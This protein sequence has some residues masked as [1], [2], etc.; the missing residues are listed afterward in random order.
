MNR[1]AK[2]H[3]L[4]MSTNINNMQHGAD[5]FGCVY[6]LQVAYFDSDAQNAVLVGNTLDFEKQLLFLWLFIKRSS[7]STCSY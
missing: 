4:D 3:L 7:A 6:T 5:A 2:A 1:K